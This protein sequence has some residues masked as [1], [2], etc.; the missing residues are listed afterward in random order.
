MIWLG[1]IIFAVFASS[2]TRILQKNI[3]AKKESDPFAFS[4]VFQIITA[5]IILAWAFFVGFEIPNNFVDIY[6]YLILMTLLYTVGNIFTFK[7]FQ[8]A[9]VSEA[10]ILL[11]TS[12]IWSIVAAYVILNEHLT[13]IRFIGIVLLISGVILVQFKSFGNKFNRGHLYALI[14]AASFGIAFIIDTINLKHFNNTFAYLFWAF[15]L[16]GVATIFIKPSVIVSAQKI[17]RMGQLKKILFTSFLFAITA[18]AF[19]SSYALGGNASVIAPLFQTSILITVI[20]SFIFLKE[21]ENP[22]R[23]II[24]TI[25]VITGAILTVL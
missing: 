21:R 15:L 11:A 4:F 18:I 6:P 3:L 25:L 20:F 2:A 1:L 22:L 9:P 14:G 23:K 24:A 8:L 12:A 13:V 7:S 16:P 5:L 17:L 19:Y 10:S